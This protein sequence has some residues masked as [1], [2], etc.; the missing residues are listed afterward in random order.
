MFIS[1]IAAMGRNRVI[2]NKN[3]LPWGRLPADMQHF[4]ALTAGK[5]VVM[6]KKTFDSIGKPLP[7]RKNVIVTH[8]D[9]EIPS[10]VVTHSIDG[11][12]L[13]GYAENVK[14]LM[15]IGGAS[16]YEQ[17]LALEG[18]WPARRLHLTCIDAEFEGDAFFPMFEGSGQWKEVLRESYLPDGKNPY[19]YSFVT[20]QRI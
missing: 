13:H 19:P 10:C 11:A 5:M 16:L 8:Q 1:L 4:R 12:I 3:A 9:I 2:G 7:N 18:E 14:E 15:V 6:G 20:F 17:F